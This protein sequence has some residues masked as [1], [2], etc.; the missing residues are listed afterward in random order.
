MKLSDLEKSRFL[1]HVIELAVA[2]GAVWL[3][4]ELAWAIGRAAR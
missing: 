4:L 3:L 1:A 2:G